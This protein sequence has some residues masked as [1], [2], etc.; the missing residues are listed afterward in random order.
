MRGLRWTGERKIRT[1]GCKCSDPA[2]WETKLR[3]VLFFRKQG[4]FCGTHNGAQS[5][6]GE[7]W[8][9]RG[10]FTR[11]AGKELPGLFGGHRH[12]QRPICSF[13]VGILLVLAWFWWISG[14]CEVKIQCPDLQMGTLEEI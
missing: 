12:Q 8:Y 10:V 3:R 11:E 5:T 4:A 1:W 14:L 9:E 6:P 2:H 7:A 13:L